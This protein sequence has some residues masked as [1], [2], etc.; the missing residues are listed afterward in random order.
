MINMN[1]LLIQ[2]GYSYDQD[3]S[4]WTRQD[5]QG[6]NYND[7]D[8]VEKRIAS[9]LNNATDLSVLSD[10]LRPH[11]IDWPSLYHL[12]ANRANI[13]RPFE[14]DLRGDILEVGAG[15]GAISRYLGECGGNVLAL[16]GT[17]RRAAI[18]SARTRDLA[19]VTVVS[20]NFEEFKYEKKF[21]VVTL[22]GVLEYANLFTPGNN[23][24]L[25]MLERVRSFLKPNGKLFI[26]IENQFGLK[27]FA[28]AP[29]DHV[30]VPMYGVE[31]R[32]RK[33]QPQ[34]YGRNE[35]G[36]LINGAG[37]ANIEFL[38]P[39]P[40]YKLP[41]SIVTERGFSND[42]FDAAALACQNVRRDPQLPKIINFSPELVWPS[43]ISN[44][45]SIDLSN[46]FLVVAAQ[47]ENEKLVC[48]KTLAWHFTTSRRKSLCKATQFVRSKDD[49]IEVLY[50]RF[51][52]SVTNPVIGNHLQHCLPEKEEY[53]LGRV[54]LNDF[55][56]NVSRD[57]WSASHISESLFSWLNCL[58]HLA[59]QNDDIVD[60]TNPFSQIAGSLFDCIPQNI[61]Q[62]RAGS[63][64]IIDNEWILNEKI[65]IGFLVY[66]GLL[67]LIN[68][69]TKFG[70]PAD[71]EIKTFYDF[72]IY[73]MKSLGWTVSYDDISRWVELEWE[74]QSEVAG[75]SVN[76]SGAMNWLVNNAL[77]I[78]NL[79]QAVS[80]RDVEIGNLNQRLGELQSEF[81]ERTAWALSLDKDLSESRFELEQIYSSKSWMLTRPIRYV[82]RVVRGEVNLGRKMVRFRPFMVQ[83]GRY[84]Y[85]KIGLS[86][87]M[88][89]RFVHLAYRFTGSLFEGT[90]HYDIWKRQ[91]GHELKKPA[92]ALGPVARADEDSLISE[93]SFPV[94][95]NPDVSVIIPAYG[96]LSHTLNCVRSIYLH[97]PRVS[98]EVLIVEDASGDAEIMRL[99]HIPGLRFVVNPENLGFLRSCNYAASLAKGKYLYFLNNDTEVMPG[100]LD[101]MVS[102][103][104]KIPDCGM[105]GSKL[106]YPDGRLQEAGGILWRDGSAWNYGR[107]DDPARSEY[108]YVKEVDYVSGHLYW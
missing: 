14:Q 34:T 84:A 17:P 47:E 101:T 66:R 57:D 5:Y 6:I 50:A 28:G 52:K 54:L 70:R 4:I 56:I 51:D 100:W 95:D 33:K 76:S 67:A 19:N 24:A 60:L 105:V 53:V 59:L 1:S 13:L 104:E 15:C 73:S 38:A 23:P 48:S 85:N 25:S 69:V 90:V 21:D 98:I 44:G 12:S 94:V 41:V 42:D 7:G 18:A 91:R 61:V 39:F 16:E 2:A 83:L 45:L 99:Q 88:K 43:I 78:T 93:L 80:D 72:L 8:E 11:C 64:H 68:S 9:I 27:Y 35:L 102:L 87:A 96:N 49:R 31:A 97:Q 75:R 65:E 71:K 62:D 22:I 74:I 30:G 82:G 63:F 3:A 103:F 89:D 20:D 108:N 79:S 36:R 86:R 106:I 29:E 58:S 46:S 77:P 32:Y 92:G 26:A 81:E 40:D 107:C 55:V 10:E 37:F